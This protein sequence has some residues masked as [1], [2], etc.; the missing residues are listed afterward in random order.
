MVEEGLQLDH[1]GYRFRA[2]FQCICC[3]KKVSAQQFAYGRACG[4][5]DVGACDVL[6]RAYEPAAVHPNPVWWSED[7]DDMVRRFAGAMH[8]SPTP[9]Q[10]KD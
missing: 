1:R 2:P 3:G 4:L 5:C 8:A 7:A 9:Q 6:N 10:E